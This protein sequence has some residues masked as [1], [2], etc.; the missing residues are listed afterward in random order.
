MATTSSSSPSMA[1]APP[2]PLPTTH[3]ALVLESFSASPS[4]QT[5]PV[6]TT[7]PGSAVI[8]VLSANI[9]SYSGALY[10]G[11]LSYPLTLPQTIG[12]SC[13]GR[14]AAL[15]PD[16]TTLK[17]GKLVLVD[18]F[19]KSRDN[20]SGGTSVLMGTHAGVTEQSGGLMEEGWRDG[21]WAEY[22]RAPLENVHGLDEEVLC[23]DG[24]GGFEYSVHQLAYLLRLVVPMGG[25]GELD[26]KAGEK[27][28]VAPA[29][30]GFSGAAVELAVA[31]GCTVV[32]AGRNEQALNELD[33]AYGDRVKTVRLVGDV[34]KDAES[35]G[36]WGPLHAYLDFSPAAA[37]DSTH[38]VS[39]LMALKNKGKAC[40]MGG[41]Q[42]PVGLPYG[43]LMFKSLR[44]SGKFMFE[45]EDV[46][47][48]IAMTEAGLIKLGDTAGLKIA[49]VFALEDWE[50]AFEIARKNSGRG[51]YA[52]FDPTMK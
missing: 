20:A 26:I 12:G 41:I 46:D 28:V 7:V 14:I 44:L 37:K 5:I 17:V 39:C 35:L 49:G 11:A 42:G 4:V 23:G 52:V 15:G 30:G 1:P 50:K 9:L 24:V 22:V 51:V 2:S 31:M 38:F 8:Q 13:I 34:G 3:R 29:T 33:E 21:S 32:A 45:N 6:P 36:Q 48:L 47:R 40:F 27:V 10:S 25:L 18:S 16:A 19:I 43:L